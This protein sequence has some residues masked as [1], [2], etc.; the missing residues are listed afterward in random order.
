MSNDT[1]DFFRFQTR[2]A[3]LAAAR[4]MNLFSNVF[5]SVALED[6]AAC[7][8]VLKILTGIKDLQIIEVRTQEHIA[9]LASRDVIL[10]VL[11]QDSTGRI[12]NIEVQRADTIDHVKRV[13][14]YRSSVDSEILKKGSNVDSLPELYIVYLSET[15]IFKSNLAWDI[16]IQKFER[17]GDEYD[18][19]CHLI[20]ANAEINENDPISSLMQYF[21]TADPDDTKHGELSQRVHFLKREKEGE[22]IMCKVSESFIQEGKR[23]GL[24]E[25]ILNLMATTKW[26]VEKAMDALQIKPDERATYA[27]FV[28]ATLAANTQ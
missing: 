26:D 15:D 10:D 24:L 19:G 5:M 9:K 22:D 3:Q 16:V 4:E 6:P 17:S 25:A 18:D 2:E 23:E 21:K 28:K 11:A 8:Y 12:Y 20:Y 13:R 7:A 27:A 1:T 14:L